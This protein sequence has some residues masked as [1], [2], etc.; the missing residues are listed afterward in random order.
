MRYREDPWE[1]AKDCVYTLD[2]QD[3]DHPIKRFPSEKE[4]LKLYFRVWQ[5]ERLLA[6]PKSRRLFMSWA[7]IIL[8]TWDTMFYTGR[9]NAVVSKKEADADNLLERAKFIIEHIPK[10]VL[11]S[12]C[13]PKFKRTYTLLEFPDI[14]STM[15]AFP[16]G[17]DQL[18]AYG[19]SGIMNDEMAFQPDAAE[20]YASTFPT[21]E[22]G[23]RFTA[24]SSPAKGFFYDLVH[25]Q[26]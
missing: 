17:S 14:K 25:D 15:Q 20:M 6:I 26:L 23:G 11:P 10:E 22:N 9:H 24:I 3:R 13:L 18:R 19:F 12:E 7:N 16:S 4:Y 8:Y 1:F 2:P 21:I 5:R